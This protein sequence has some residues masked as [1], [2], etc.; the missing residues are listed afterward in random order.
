MT[1]ESITGERAAEAARSR[2]PVVHTWQATGPAR[3]ESV[4]V[5]ISDA[6]LRAYGRLVAAG[7]P[8]AGTEPYSASFEASVDKADS[9]GRVLLRTTTAEHERQVAISRSADG[10]W[11]VDRGAETQR[12]DFG[13]ALT[14]D[15]VGAVT[16]TTLPV[17]HLR[18]HRE[19]GE[20]EIPVVSVSLPDLAITVVRHTYRTVSL[21]DDG[22]T[23][24][25]VR[26]G[27]ALRI[28]VDRDG[29]VIDQGVAVR[30]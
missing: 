3:L 7:D 12:D 4:R 24:D 26:D 1:S 10:V 18:L 11:L 16:F 14:V 21:D 2:K 8:D 22:A 25:L 27:S 17:R 29:V 15:V 19:A 23:I 9:A 28:K 6:R 20:F 30:L 5:L 13:G